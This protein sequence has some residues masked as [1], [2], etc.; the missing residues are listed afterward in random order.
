MR[1][2]TFILLMLL[3]VSANAALIHDANETPI[4]WDFNYADTPAPKEKILFNIFVPKCQEHKTMDCAKLQPDARVIANKK[5][6]EI[7]KL[8]KAKKHE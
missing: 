1:I 8:M 5:A 7:E 2:F 4:G 6:V 3:P